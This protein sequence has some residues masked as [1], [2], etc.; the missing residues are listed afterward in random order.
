[1]KTPHLILTICIT[2]I[3]FSCSSKKSEEAPKADSV[4]AYTSSAPPPPVSS[5]AAVENKNDSNRKFVR[6]ADLRFKVKNVIKSSYDIEAI[7]G[8]QGGFI[9]STELHSEI[10]D[11][12][13]ERIS[14]DSIL[15]MTRFSV[16]NNITIRVPNTKLDTTLKLI[17]RN[18]IFLDY[19]NIKANDVSLQLLSNNLTQKRTARHADRLTKAVDEK[20]KKLAESTDAEELILKQQED[21]DNAKIANLDLTDQI[22]FSTIT[23]CIYQDESVRKEIIANTIDNNAPGFWSK[24]WDSVLFGW[25]IL[26]YLITLIIK[27]WSFIIIGGIIVFVYQKFF[28]KK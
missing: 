8:Q 14:R 18:I 7:V 26:S 9:T 5:S 1:M 16:I 28:R 27:L 3:L 23:L 4:A 17:A 21:A 20:G 6:T 25:D 22:K 13:K 10:N 2:T 12:Q 15:E 19:R 11:T 24:I